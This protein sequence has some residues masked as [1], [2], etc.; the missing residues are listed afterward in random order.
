[1]LDI[2][3]SSNDIYIAISQVLV[4]IANY[5]RYKLHE[6]PTMHQIWYNCGYSFLTGQIVQIVAIASIVIFCFVNPYF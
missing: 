4:M 1:M 2:F 6:D 5:W 3:L